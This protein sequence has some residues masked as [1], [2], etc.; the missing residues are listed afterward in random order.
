MAGQDDSYYRQHSALL[1]GTMH[2]KQHVVSRPFHR[3]RPPQSCRGQATAFKV[4]NGG[5]S[6]LGTMFIIW[7]G[8]RSFML[9]KYNGFGNWIGH[10]SAVLQLE[11][12]KMMQPI[13]GHALYIWW[14][15]IQPIIGHA[16]CQA[17]SGMDSRWISI[18]HSDS[19][20]ARNGY[21][22]TDISCI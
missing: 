17:N 20:M 22:C 18:T 4:S 11:H 9:Q 16:L 8:K 10:S 1:P 3:L 13:S 7:P 6:H 19:W 5:A 12:G 15:M 21:L 14:K 2:Q